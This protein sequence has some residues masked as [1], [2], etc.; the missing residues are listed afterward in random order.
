M[1]RANRHYLPGYVWHLTHRCHKKEF[2]LK[3]ARDRR[4]WVKWLF[5]ARKR[6]GIRVLNYI[7][8]SNHI[9]LLVQDGDKSSTIPKTMQLIAGRVGQEYNKRKQRKGAFWEDRYHAT[10]VENDSH[11]VQCMVYID[12]NM[13]RAGVVRHPGEWTFGGYGEIM[14]PR[15]RYS[16]IDHE[17]LMNLLDVKDQNDLQRMYKDWIDEAIQK[18]NQLRESR[19]TESVAVGSEAFVLDTKEKLGLKGKGRKVVEQEDAFELREG[20]VSYSS[21][22]THENAVLSEKNTYYWDVNY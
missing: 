6:Y 14:K 21:N 3:F 1:A 2:L 17:G 4:L 19:W 22:F 20:F 16:V 18:R 8:T 7:V 13:V 11:L 9:H 15:R 5:E 12:M 10:A